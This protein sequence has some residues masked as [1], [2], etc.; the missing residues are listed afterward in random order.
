MNAN[1][2]KSHQYH[3]KGDDDIHPIIRNGRVIL[4]EVLPGSKVNQTPSAITLSV[5]FQ[6]TSPSAPLS[7]LVAT[8]VVIAAYS[9]YHLCE[10]T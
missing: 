9:P 6:F 10:S 4:D 2:L 1:T 7:L 5:I 8:A 3:A